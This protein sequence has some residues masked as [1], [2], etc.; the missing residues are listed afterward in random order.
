MKKTYKKIGDSIEKKAEQIVEKSRE[1]EKTV[2][3]NF[4]KARNS[5]VSADDGPLAHNL[6]TDPS[7]K[8]AAKFMNEMIVKKEKRKVIS[9]AELEGLNKLKEKIEE[10]KAKK[11]DLSEDDKKILKKLEDTHEKH[12]ED[13][14]EFYKNDDN[15]DLVDETE[16]IVVN[17]SDVSELFK[18]LLKY[19]LLLCIFIY[20]IVLI[21][22]FINVINLIFLTIKFALNLFYNPIIVN[23]DTLS[24]KLKEII[25]VNKNDFSKDTCNVF[26]EQLMA[27]SIFNMTIYIFYILLAYL[28]IYI[29]WYIYYNKVMFYT[30]KLVGD[31]K[32]IDPDGNLMLI[33]VLL[34]ALGVV[35]IVIYKFILKNTG[36]YHYKKVV[37][38]ETNLDN[39]ILDYLK[40]SSP[41]P[42][43][44]EDKKFY[45]L[46]IDSTKYDEINL[47]F[48]KKINNLGDG[49]SDIGKYMLI[50]NL[51]NYFSN[52]IT[53]NDVY[54][55]KIGTYLQLIPKI[56]ND[57]EEVSFLSLLD[58]S[59]KRL[60]KLSHEDLNFYKNIPKDKIEIFKPINNDIINI[61]SN[62]NKLI[63]SYSGTFI[64]F[65]LIAVYIVVIFV[66]NI[67]C[68]YILFE[69]IHAT[70][71]KNLFP[72][73]IYTM[74]DYY[75]NFINKLLDREEE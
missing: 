12:K 6:A 20:I 18:T 42:F 9:K 54:Q 10:I 40:S 35:H 70:K 34:F 46:L 7:L 24:F 48:E 2:T 50:Y 53:M 74:T 28:F 47:F 19:L 67:V 25:K 22:S 4:K 58:S 75:K 1:I 62:I 14:T 61:V 31:V 29:L 3:D 68:I 36:I 38:Y 69:T 43:S 15:K 39:S 30:H 37:D 11:E 49:D 17:F 26:S 63:I 21:I 55:Y 32:E 66:Y 73:Y 65:I 72:D 56:K 33:I 45:Y 16:R 27:L 52:Y 44:V 57:N 41:A 5:I 51:Y 13:I 71:A 59:N 60:I 8:E 64:P 23:N